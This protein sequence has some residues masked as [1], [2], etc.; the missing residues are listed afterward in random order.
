MIRLKSRTLDCREYVFT[1]QIRIVVVENLMW[2]RETHPANRA[3][4]QRVKKAFPGAYT[5]LDDDTLGWSVQVK[6][7]A[8]LTGPQSEAL[9]LAARHSVPSFWDCYLIHAKLGLIFQLRTYSP[10]TLPPTAA[11]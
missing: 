8:Y 9:P 3:I 10:I 11:N 4:G 7:S 6:Y 1:F 5:D 2:I